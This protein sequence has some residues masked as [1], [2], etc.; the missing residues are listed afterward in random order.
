MIPTCV[1]SKD[2]ACQL[3]LFLRSAAQ[4]SPLLTP[5]T[6][7]WTA[8]DQLFD[9]GY[10]L[11][12]SEHPE[13]IFVREE[14]YKEDILCW[15][16]GK[17]LAC[18]AVDDDVIF[19]PLGAAMEI[20]MADERILAFC[21]RL[22]GNTTHCYPLDAAQDTPFPKVVSDVY[23]A[24]EWSGASLDFGY[25]GS[26]DGNVFRASD[27]LPIAEGYDFTNPNGLEDAL[28]QWFNWN[29][30]GKRP[31]LASYRESAVVNNPA[32][33]VNVTH[34]NRRAVSLLQPQYELNRRYLAGERIDL[35][36]MD[37]SGVNAA[38]YEMRYVLR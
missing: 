38:H 6:V 2:R 33:I 25:P 16:A 12:A 3:D 4:N 34:P 29:M 36:A 26:L 7:V 9:M 35:D 22:G 17:D 1:S 23:I 20:A 28:A 8:S 37:F 10:E 19:R 18:F 11:C 31:L 21:P 14:S 27:I 30:A 32:N 15:L 13:A 24:W 5:V